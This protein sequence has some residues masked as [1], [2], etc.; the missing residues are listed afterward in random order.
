[1]YI[2]ILSEQYHDYND[3]KWYKEL[4]G[5]AAIC[6][7][8]QNANPIVSSGGLAWIS[9]MVRVK[10]RVI[11]NNGFMIGVKVGFWLGLELEFY[12]GLRKELVS[13][14]ELLKLI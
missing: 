4:L 6:L 10:V 2:A 12:F 14:L 13:D 11:I 7:P 9:P 5:K 8:S 1:M 3:G